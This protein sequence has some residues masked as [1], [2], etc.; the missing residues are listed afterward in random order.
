MFPPRSAKLCVLL[1]TIPTAST[2]I[3]FGGGQL[4]SELSFGAV[5]CTCRTFPLS[6]TESR[7]RVREF[8]ASMFEHVDAQR[9]VRV[10]ESA[11]LAEQRREPEGWR[12]GAAFLCLL[13][14]AAQRK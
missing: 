13:S 9:I 10:Y 2:E 5:R 6:A 7:R 14:L 4:R 3:Q 1:H 8:L 12:I 11:C